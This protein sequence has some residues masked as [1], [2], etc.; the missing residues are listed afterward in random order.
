MS[1][2]GA[3]INTIY[4]DDLGRAAST[5]EQQAWVNLDT[6]GTLTD[7][8]VIAGIVNSAEAQGSG[9]NIV[10][11]YQAAF[12]RIPDQAGYIANTAATDSF[13][14]GAL[15]VL[16]VANDM[17]GSQEFMNH[18]GNLVNQTTFTSP[19]LFAVFIASLYQ[20]VL[21]RNGSQAEINAWLATGD[22]AAQ[23]LLGFANS[24]E[25]Q[26]KANP[27]VAALLTLN[28]NDQIA[29]T[30]STALTGVG[31]LIAAGVQTF[32]LTENID[33][34]TATVAGTVFNA[35]PVTT[36]VGTVGNTLNPGDTLTDTVGDG[37]L[38]IIDVFPVLAG[39]APYSPGVTISGIKTLNITNNSPLGA[40]GAIP[41]PI[42]S[43]FQGNVTGLTTV[44]DSASIANVT[45]GAIGQGLKTALTT[46]NVS[47]YA[48]PVSTPAMPDVIF[49]AFIAA[50][51][52]SASNSLAITLSGIL[53]ATVLNGAD[54]VS[55]ANDGA[56]GTAAA[57]NLSYGTQTY[58]VNSNA[59][60]QLQAESLVPGAPPAPGNLA[61]FV[62]SVDGTT[63]FNF[64]GTGNMAIGQDA[65]GDHVKVT[66]INAS[67]ATGSV[68]ITGHATNP[69]FDAIAGVAA[70][71][72][73]A[74]STATNPAGLFGS[75][76]GFL[77]DATGFALTTFNLG[78]GVNTLDISSAT[79]AQVAALT[80]VP[81]T[82]LAATNEIIVASAVAD[83]AVSSTFGN[84]KGFS[85]L[86]DVTPGGTINLANLPTS[87]ND[88][89]YQTLSGGALVI[90]N[91]TANLTVDT[92]AN[93]FGN[94]ITVG[95]VGASTSLT[96]AF[97]LI[98]GDTVT[99]TK[100]TVGAVTLAG[101]DIVG[102]MSQGAAG[103]VV[104][105]MLL[106][107][108]LT[109]NEAVTISGNQTI[110]IGSAAGGGIADVSGAGLLNFGNMSMNITDT[111]AVTLVAATGSGALFFGVPG[112]TVAGSGPGGNPLTNS[113][114]AVTINAS[115]SGGLIMQGGD[116]NF[117]T[118]ATVAGSTGDVIT[119]ATGFGNVLGGSI[120]NDTIVGTTSLTAPDTIYTG[121]GADTITLAAGHTAADQ[122]GLYSGFGTPGV[123]PGGIEIPRFVSIT[124]TN[125]VPQLGWWGQ[126]TGA[127]ATGY[128]ATK[129]AGLAADSGTS[130]DQTTVANFVVGSAAT[131][132]DS[133]E[134]GANVGV[135]HGAI[136]GTGGTNGNGGIAHGLVFGDLVTPTAAVAGG[137][138]AVLQQVNP[139]TAAV[140][141]VNA[142]T[143]VLQLSTGVFQNANAVVNALHT[144]AYTLTFAAGAALGANDS[145]HLLVAYQD[146][147]GSTHVMDLAITNTAAV[148]SGALESTSTATVSLYGSD[149]VQLTGVG[150]L[151]LHAG[152]IHF[153]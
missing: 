7:S 31:P 37:T 33:N 137:T 79:A 103:D 100:G 9:W 127:T 78:S 99:A 68:Y 1:L 141:N 128:A 91:Q 46:V 64:A 13:A 20:S 71:S 48:G 148:A 88:I 106:T 22:S 95:L 110:T 16:Q 94:A 24:A 122:I 146:Q 11:L 75:S 133:M 57:P 15:S 19:Q 105:A 8:Q 115:T 102:V 10:R 129:Y 38:N 60:L 49:A 18:F 147:A 140:A 93:G 63:T 136:W 150:L 44:N 27:A 5:A 151:T 134:F 56:P 26:A 45:L 83:T 52:G 41:L 47:G 149:I 12:N 117:T 32:T 3:Q 34:F 144:G 120:G 4:L 76:A 90:N 135:G 123:L 42:A 101:D 116:A 67:T 70:S 61:A 65:I 29:A 112:D 124:D 125:D 35:L 59:N 30:P 108:A 138:V 113:T 145:E 50:A 121:G 53:G 130:A 2:T 23:V 80:T 81:G 126:A 25:F 143:D 84:I 86:G 153:V 89:F 28:A 55:I 39:N 107:P 73:N 51:A 17:I 92:E 74:I 77:D 139:G 97:S 66:T 58:T 85:I 114:N 82:T 132:Q 69:I 62:P 104:G 6:S 109:G 36:S 152:N 96:T 21:A 111:K 119:G 87:I 43:G 40:I 118:A 54:I 72:T 142:A 14:G 98:V 131:P